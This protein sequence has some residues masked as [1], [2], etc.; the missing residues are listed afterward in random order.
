M[1]LPHLQGGSESFLN[2]DCTHESVTVQFS[3]SAFGISQSEHDACH[4][5]LL[6]LSGLSFASARPE[7]VHCPRSDV[8]PTVRAQWCTRR[9]SACKSNCAISQSFYIK[10]V[11]CALSSTFVG[12]PQGYFRCSL[13]SMIRDPPK[14]ENISTVHS[15]CSIC[16]PCMT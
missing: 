11:L 10:S 1:L 14:R 7:T 13:G 8:V 16:W 4:K 5:E 9:Q 3:A 2:R 6:K 15:L 12:A